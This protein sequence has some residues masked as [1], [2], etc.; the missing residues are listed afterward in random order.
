MTLQQEILEEAKKFGICDKFRKELEDRELT[1]DQLLTMY[2][3]G[4]DFCMEN[5]FPS[6]KIVRQ[7]RI[8]DLHRNGIYYDYD[9]DI[10]FRKS[11]LVIN[12]KSNVDVTISR[13]TTLYLRDNSKARLTLD[14]GAFCYVSLHD[15]SQ[16]EI[17]SKGKGAKVFCSLFSGEIVTPDMFNEIHYK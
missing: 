12:G 13:V 17:V 1:T 11:F 6:R 3:R 10:H 16:V 4:L 9:G 7:F 8:A 2:H 5:N 15:N 14:D